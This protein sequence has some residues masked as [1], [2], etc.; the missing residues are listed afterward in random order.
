VN[1][2]HIKYVNTDRRGYMVVEAGADQLKVAFQAP[3]TVADPKSEVTTL[4]SFRVASGNPSVE[5]VS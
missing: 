2:P 4:A 3:A 1:N 5:Q